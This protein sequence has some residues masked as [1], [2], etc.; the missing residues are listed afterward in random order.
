M[1]RDDA[2]IRRWH[3]AA[4]G[5]LVITYEEFKRVVR[6]KPKPAAA[7]AGAGAE[8]GM[9]NGSAMAE[10]GSIAPSEMRSSAAVGAVAAAAANGT[11]GSRPGTALENGTSNGAGSNRAAA[12]ASASGATGQRRG[13]EGG[14][15]GVA[16]PTLAEMLVSTP[17][18]VVVDEGHVIKNQK[19]STRVLCS[20]WDGA[21]S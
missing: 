16:E 10:N 18:V 9:A 13:I 8:S 1:F 4:T 12:G 17:N 14:S 11:G 3:G 2:D 15:S 20:H 21:G 19:A 7:A 6:H 5:T